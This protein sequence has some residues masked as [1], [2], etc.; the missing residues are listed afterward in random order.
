MNLAED[1]YFRAGLIACREA[2][3]RFVE[4]QSPEIAE[5]GPVVCAR[6]VPGTGGNDGR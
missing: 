4:A 2:M 6:G 5:P 1:A 3:A